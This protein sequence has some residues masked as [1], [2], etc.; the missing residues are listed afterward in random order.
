MPSRQE[1]KEQLIETD[2]EFRRLYEAHQSRERRL[3]ELLESHPDSGEAEVEL[4]ALKVEK[5]HLKDRMEAMIRDR[6][7]TQVPTGP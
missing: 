5:L 7:D 6:L 2:N 1:V 3:D 4:K